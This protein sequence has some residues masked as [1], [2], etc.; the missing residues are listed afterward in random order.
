MDKKADFFKGESMTA[1]EIIRKKRD[2]IKLKEEE[3][4]FFVNGSVKGEIK[5]YQIAAFLMAIYINGMD[6]EE[7]FFLTREMLNSGKKFN[8]KEIK[9]KKID[10]HST[11]GVGDKIS[12]ILA[13]LAA[14]CGIVVPMISG[15]GLG[16]TGGTIDKLEA[17]KGYNPLLDE[18]KF[19]DVLKETGCAIISQ[20]EDIAPCDRIF[21]SIRDVT[22]TVE[23]IPLITSSI[24]SKKLAEDLDGLVIDM[25]LGKGAFMKNIDEAKRLA[26]SMMKVAERFNLKMKIFFTDMNTP[27]GY[28]IG[29]GIEV[30]ESK[31]ILKGEVKNDTYKI[32]MELVKGMCEIAGIKE[33]PE[34]YIENKEAYRRFEKMVKLQGG[35]INKISLNKNEYEIKSE[36]QG[37]VLDV[38]AYSIAEAFLLSGAGRIRKED[39]IDYGAGIRLLKFIGDSVKKNE[40]IAIVHTSKDIKPISMKIKE[41]YNI[42]KG[43]PVIKKRIIEVW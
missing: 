43:E 26:E 25:K 22:G 34:K 18:K 9:G 23:S 42:G 1:V 8:L 40:T 41:G 38:D 36:K 35:D 15:R 24:M 32:T 4:R 39:K 28:G 5:D 29:N 10:K 33:E 30:I 12:I 16:H 13:P 37:I 19:K 17:I 6:F 2:R 7:T 20:T 14:S 27:I 21:Y 3:I 31:E 11:G